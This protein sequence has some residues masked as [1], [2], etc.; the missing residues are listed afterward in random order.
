MKNVRFWVRAAIDCA[1]ISRDLCVQRKPL[2]WPK[3]PQSISTSKWP[4]RLTFSAMID[5]DAGHHL[6]QS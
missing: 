4:C 6:A 3:V 1:M 5:E 2:A